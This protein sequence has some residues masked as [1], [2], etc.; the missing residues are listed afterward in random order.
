MDKLIPIYFQFM[1]D[2]ERLRS[3]QIAYVL[4]EYAEHQGLSTKSTHKMRKT[5][6]S[7][8]NANGVPLV[9]IQQQLGHQHMETTLG[10]LKNAY[11]E[12][13]TYNLMS[14]AV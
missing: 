8:L 14:K 11:T 7:N 2:G 10:Y 6:A 5:F 13:E 1:R 4:E 12:N 9:I 3:R